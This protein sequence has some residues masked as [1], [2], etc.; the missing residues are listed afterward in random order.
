MMGKVQRKLA[1]A[2]VV[3]IG[4]GA[5]IGCTYGM[6]YSKANEVHEGNILQSR[7]NQEITK[8]ELQGT[9]IDAMIDS[10]NV[11]QQIV[12]VE[13]K[14]TSTLKLQKQDAKWNSWLTSAECE[15]SVETK[16]LIGIDVK[17]LMMVQTEHGLVIQYQI[18]DF[19]VLSLEVVNEN[20]ISSRKIFA[21]PYTDDDKSAIKS[22]IQDETK[23]QLLE[24]DKIIKQANQA[25]K[26]YLYGL[27]E[28]FGV[29]VEIIDVK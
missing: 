24:N 15:V 10:I 5:V 2:G 8:T 25:L 18:E 20:I 29:D 12:L 4:T 22:Y 27:G 6:G 19:E 21:Q 23:A 7:I 11:K 13:Q 16:A 1:T 26:D 17:D 14:G 3:I 28:A 9:K